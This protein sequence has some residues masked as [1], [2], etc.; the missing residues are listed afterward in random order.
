MTRT[1]FC[2]R[3]DGRGGSGS[4][5]A[6]ALDRTTARSRLRAAVRTAGRSISHSV[7]GQPTADAGSL[8]LADQLVDAIAPAMRRFLRTLR[9]LGVAESDAYSDVHSV[10]DECQA[11]DHP[12]PERRNLLAEA[13]RQISLEYRAADA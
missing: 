10:I 12:T 6:D 11:V 9:D 3:M 1:T 5:A 8:A 13:R 2:G 4:L 7:E